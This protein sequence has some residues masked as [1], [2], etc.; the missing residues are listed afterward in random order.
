MSE[1]KIVFRHTDEILEFV[2]VVQNFPYNM[3]MKHGNITVDAKSL[4]G[5][6]NLGLQ[7]E[8]ELKVYEENCDDLKAAVQ[9]FAA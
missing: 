9:R 7:R 3:D 2:N 5:L 1:L 4:L 8:C 6:M